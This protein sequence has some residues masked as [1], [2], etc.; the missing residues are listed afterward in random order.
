M[1]TITTYILALYDVIHKNGQPYQNRLCIPKKLTLIILE[2]QLS[3]RRHPNRFHKRLRN[4]APPTKQSL[5][6]EFF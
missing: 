4:S 5:I 3:M 2:P 1:I 6:S